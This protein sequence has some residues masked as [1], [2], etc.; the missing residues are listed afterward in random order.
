MEDDG[1]S[2]VRGFLVHWRHADGGD[3]EERELDRQATSTLLEVMENN[4]LI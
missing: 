3:W 4:F 1:G 2:P